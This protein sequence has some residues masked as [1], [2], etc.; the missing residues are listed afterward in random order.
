[1][2]AVLFNLLGEAKGAEF[3]SRMSIASHGPERDTG[4]TGNFF[5]ILWSIPGVAQSGPIRLACGRLLASVQ[6]QIPDRSS[7]P[8]RAG[9]LTQLSRRNR[10]RRHRSGTGM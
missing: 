8:S 2:A 5:N 6:E 3:F 9:K 4:H 7:A 10:V 1:M